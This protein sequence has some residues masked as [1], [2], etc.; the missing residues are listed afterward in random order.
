MPP[1]ARGSASGFRRTSCFVNPG[2]TSPAVARA[3]HQL[4]S[5]TGGPEG[6]LYVP[7]VKV[8]P[9]VKVGHSVQVGLRG[10]IGPPGKI[11]RPVKVVPRVKAGLRVKAVEA[12]L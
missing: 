3:V 8:G 2:L 4:L 9:P 5:C 1:S 6:R 7:W 12:G 10:K 11:G